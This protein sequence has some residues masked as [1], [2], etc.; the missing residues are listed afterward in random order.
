MKILAIDTSCTVATAAVMDDNKLLGEY[1]IDDKLTHS[2]KLMPMIDALLKELNLTAKDIDVFAVSTGPGSFT[3]LR[4]GIATAKGFAA[5]TGKDMVGVSTLKAMAYRHPM[6]ALDI[7][8][9]I[10]ARNA[11]VFCGK[12]KFENG[13]KT[14]L[15]PQV[16]NIDDIINEITTPTL[17]MGDGAVKNKEAL[18]ANKNIMFA[19]PHL[20]MPSAAAVAAAGV[21]E[22]KENGTKTPDEV[23][24]VY[25][26]KSQAEQE[27]ERMNEK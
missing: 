15:E 11:Q 21:D 16:K 9:M 10:D 4:I 19:P 27:K 7:M 2:Q 13:C 23:N 12:Y 8:P 3:G 14:L 5:G 20:N 6:C 24:A 1:Y 26:R 22:I 25:I 18:M 17:V